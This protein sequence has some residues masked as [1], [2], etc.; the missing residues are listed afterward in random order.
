M[1]LRREIIIMDISCDTINFGKKS[2]QGLIEYVYQLHKKSTNPP[3]E[4]FALSWEEIGPGY[5][6]GPAF[7]HWDIVHATMDTLNFDVDHAKNQM[8]NTLS[9]QLPNG[10]LPSIVW[11][12][13]EAP[14][15]WGGEATHPP[16]W[17]FVVDEI[18]RITKDNTFLSKA[19]IHLIKQLCWFESNRRAEGEGFY[20]TDILNNLWES[21]VDEGIRFK[22]ITTGK[23]AC[24]DAT[25]HVFNLYKNAEKWSEI[26]GYKAS[27]YK[28]RGEELKTFIQTK[29]FDNETGFFHDIWAVNKADKRRMA[30]E[31]M[32]PIV[33]GATT[34]EQADRVIVENLLNENVFFT[35]HPMATVDVKDA[36][37]ELRM[38]RGPAWNSMTF[39][40]AKGCMEYGRRDAAKLLLER[41]LDQTAK[42]FEE[43]HTVWEFYN[44]MGGS[45]YEVKRKPHTE[46]N[47][48][49]KDYLGHN[50]II[51]MAKMWSEAKK[52]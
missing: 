21:G 3:R 45:Q 20:Y 18:Y 15:D 5:C 16:V 44:S 8:I 52:E 50:P 23:F 36:D 40:A 28:K 34:E 47:M 14:K 19:Y 32:W 29:L 27:E 17:V 30:F 9:L 2:W 49:C 33:V 48:P 37:F 46:F 26:L 39:W 7:G 31:G 25:A 4:P 43:T 38:W 24:V 1:K 22:D 13:K 11:M 41:A 6:Y 35:P 51:A 10:K 42:K 12:K